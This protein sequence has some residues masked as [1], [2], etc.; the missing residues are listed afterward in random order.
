MCFYLPLPLFSSQSFPGLISLWSPLDRGPPHTA[1][2][3]LGRVIAWIKCE[4]VRYWSH[5]TTF[6]LSA[7]MCKPLVNIEAA[8]GHSAGAVRVRRLC[9][10][11]EVGLRFK[12]QQ[13]H[14]SFIIGWQQEWEV[15][16]QTSRLY[17]SQPLGVTG[18]PLPN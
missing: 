10:F 2:M 8:N 18:L 13:K 16:S 5:Q 3:Q 1:M 11:R 17:E 14:L 15:S 4:S 6:L 7:L 9:V 12:C